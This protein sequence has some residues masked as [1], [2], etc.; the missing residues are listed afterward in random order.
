MT[1]DQVGMAAVLAAILACAPAWSQGANLVPNGSFEQADGDQPA[2]WEQRTPT[3]EARELMWAEGVARTGKRSLKIVNRQA[4]Q[5]RWRTG[6]LGDL[7]LRPGSQAVLTGWIKA[8]G[9]AESAHL[10]LYCLKANGSIASQPGSTAV[11]GDAG[12]TEVKLEHRIPDDCAFVMVYAEMNGPGTAWYDDLGLW[13]E[14]VEPQALQAKPLTYGAADFEVLDGFALVKRSGRE[15]LQLGEQA[16]SGKARLIFDGETARYDIAISYLDEF[17]GASQLRMLLNGR[18]LGE[19]TFDAT[20]G[21]S[22]EADRFLQ[23]QIAG[24]D[25]QRHSRL[26]LEGKKDGEEYCRVEQVTFKPVGHF[27]GELLP[28]E[29]VKLPPSLRVFPTRAEEASARRM[30]RQLIARGAQA[31]SQQRE[32]ELAQ[33]KTPEQWRAYQAKIHDRLAEYFGAWPERTPLN[34][35]VV[36][37][38]EREKFTIEKVIFEPQPRYYATA[39]LYVPK[40]RPLPAPGVIFTCGHSPE[41]KG[42]HLYHE[43]CLG[44]VLKGYVV[45][46]LDP[47]GQG[48]R[49]E[50]F[51]PETLKNLVPLTVSQHHY[52]GRPSFLVGWS[53]SGRRTWDCIR[54]VDYL[55][56][57]PEVQADK[58]A[59]CGNS[60]GGQMAVLITAVDERI[61]VCAAAH[62]GGSMENT[63]LN[64]QGL[65]DREVLSLIPPRP[66]AFIVGK[67]S[68]EAGGHGARMKDLLRFYEGLGVGKE[69]GRMILVE[70]V[71]DMKRPKRVAAYGWLNKWFGREEE[72]AEEP[73][74]EP[75]T[76][77]ELW[78]TKSGFT[79]KSLGG[80]SGQTLNVK[81]LDR[82]APQR[83]APRDRAAA[84]RMQA[85]LRQAVLRRLG[86]KIEADHQAPRVEER[87]DFTGEGFGAEKFAYESEPGLR[88]PALLLIPAKPKGDAPIVLHASDLGKPRRPDQA[89]LPLALVRRGYTVLTIDVRGVG[90][91]DVER[92]RAEPDLTRYNP[93]QWRRDSLAINAVYSGRTL[94]AMRALDIVRGID[95]LQARP[96]L[97]G[98]RVVLVGEGLGGLWAL[99]VGAADERVAGVATVGML[100]SYRSLISSQY[101]RVRGYFWVVGAVQDY[102]LPDLPALLAPRPVVTLDAVNAMK[103]PLS[104]ANSARALAWAQAVY[105]ALGAQGRCRCQSTRHQTPAEQAEA[106]ARALDL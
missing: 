7:A 104:A 63:Y 5:S 72:G 16:P 18:P 53:L 58:L 56:S 106:L 99:A 91:T 40:S 11:K 23:K 79:L 68:G 49:S 45:L 64:G 41:G 37:K 57:R 22:Q 32:S 13:G 33:L 101:Y 30:L 95:W 92:L 15:V 93:V 10:R 1:L 3:D 103:E 94:A 46:A 12:W 51:D 100:Q 66:C 2:F 85:A 65:R 88:V 83:Q 90:E 42:Y 28:P 105:E 71:H 38:I 52:L 102:D 19:F 44:L 48:E 89:S 17:D 31:K 43:S 21:Q 87:G 75:F 25:V 59:A 96:E 82:L 98:K 73:P 26:V 67:K 6:Y 70:G 35:R 62:P 14:A 9:V 54:A 81:R 61:K 80:E 55:V 34:A 8:Q 77:Q 36:G 27:V 78:C 97:K 24:V 39:N 20:K 50:Y 47:T 29:A 76:A 69:R 74:L 84:K 60:G 4:I 86:L